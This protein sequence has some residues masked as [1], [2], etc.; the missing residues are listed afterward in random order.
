MLLKKA[1]LTKCEAW[2]KIEAM[3]PPSDS[4]WEALR[5]SGISKD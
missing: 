2:L 3:W 1:G 4:L 5:V